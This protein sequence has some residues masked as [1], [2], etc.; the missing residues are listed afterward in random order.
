MIKNYIIVFVLSVMVITAIVLGFI[1][2]GNPFQ[3]RSGKFD[4]TR[5]SNIQSLSSSIDNYYSSN[6]KF[7][8]SLDELMQSPGARSYSSGKEIDKD[9]ETNKQ[10]EF[11]VT[12]QYTYKICA[13]FNE[14]QPKNQ[15]NFYNY[16]KDLQYKKGHQC[17]DLTLRGYGNQTPS[18]QTANPAVPAPSPTPDN[19]K[20]GVS[21]I[22]KNGIPYSLVIGTYQ[23]PKGQ[24]EVNVNTI[25]KYGDRKTVT[26]IHTQN[27]ETDFVDKEGKFI[28]LDTFQVGDR[29]R[30]EANTMRAESYDANTIQ[31]LTR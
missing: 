1:N 10:F 9:P 23:G 13:D 16:N 24:Y 30:I 18:S 5:I 17:F 28:K 29:V 6:R 15:E 7:P 20:D 25:D 22:Y 27:H 21:V 31:N 3:I 2:A 12:G 26:V 11:S 8:G 4:A 14:D 19:T